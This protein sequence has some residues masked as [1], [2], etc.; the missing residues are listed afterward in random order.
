MLVVMEVDTMD[1]AIEIINK[2][3]Y[4]NGTAIFTTSGNTARRLVVVVIERI[5]P[6]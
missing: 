2:N 4:G 6:F 3:I 5:R 1:E